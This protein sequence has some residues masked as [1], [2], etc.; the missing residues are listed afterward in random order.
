MSI[1]ALL[2]NR[3]VPISQ[4]EIGFEEAAIVMAEASGHHIGVPHEQQLGIFWCWAAV[5]VAMRAFLRKDLPKMSQCELAKIHLKHDH[6]CCAAG[7]PIPDC[8]QQAALEETLKKAGVNVQPPK[9]VLSFS[10][11][12][13]QLSLDR[14]VCV[15]IDFPSKPDHFVQ[16][17]G[18]ENDSYS[19]N[20]PERG[21]ITVPDSELRTNYRN[22]KGKWQ[23]TYLLA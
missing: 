18:F 13:G 9:S 2:A 6:D 1:P 14:P 5:S 15:L 16:I 17:D 19:I 23:K 11:V 3:L 7:K 10:T 20:D 22:E 4:P 12:T 8:D 21:A